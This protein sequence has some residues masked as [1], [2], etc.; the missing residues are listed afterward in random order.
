MCDAGAM[1][2]TEEEVRALQGLLDRSF[3][4]ASEHLLAIM[5][6][7]RRLDAGRLL[8]EVDDVCVLNVATVTAHGEPR[9]TPSLMKT[10]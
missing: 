8:R 6:D 10:R 1:Y 2:E 5:T 9:I 4:A 7:P 3:A